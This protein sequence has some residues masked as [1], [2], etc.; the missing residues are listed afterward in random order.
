M[1][2]RHL[3][4][5]DLVRCV[6]NRTGQWLQDQME[7]QGG[8]KSNLQ[9]FIVSMRAEIESALLANDTLKAG[10]AQLFLSGALSTL[11]HDSVEVSQRPLLGWLQPQHVD[12]MQQLSLH[13]GCLARSLS[14]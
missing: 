1:H 13:P 7:K 12:R 3:L 10:F 11:D 6:G 14:N 2:A 4:Q 8:D 5:D 9:P